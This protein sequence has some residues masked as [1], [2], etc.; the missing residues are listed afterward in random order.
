MVLNE[1]YFDSIRLNVKWKK[2]YS[3]SQVDALLD[4]I[5]QKAAALVDEKEALCRQLNEENEALRRQLDAELA[6]AEQHQA[7]SMRQQEYAVQKVQSCYARM[8]QQYISSI[9]ALNADWQDFLCDLL[10]EEVE[11]LPPVP[12]DMA[13]KVSAIA[14]ELLAIG[15]AED[16]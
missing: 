9:E 4:D 10:P 11:S 5:R 13:E 3:V 2:Y 1:E 12:A 14:N 6:K 8:R 16:K 7:E 15:T